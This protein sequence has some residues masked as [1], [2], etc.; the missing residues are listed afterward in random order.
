MTLPTPTAGRG[1]PPSSAAQELNP[2]CCRQ[3][4]VSGQEEEDRGFIINLLQ[5]SGKLP[6]CRMSRSGEGFTSP[7][8]GLTQE[9]VLGNASSHLFPSPGSFP[10]SSQ[11]PGYAKQS[12]TSALGQGDFWT[13]CW[14]PAWFGIRA[15]ASPAL[16]CCGAIS[17]A[18]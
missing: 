5:L 6:T 4:R 10:G 3:Q 1:E 2:R 13:M 15:R 18:C 17:P 12:F 14:H 8:T 7:S 9:P 11:M 16:I